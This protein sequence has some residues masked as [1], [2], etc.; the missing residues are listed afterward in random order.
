MNS[1]GDMEKEIA[2]KA[3][4]RLL[5]ELTK[6]SGQ[7]TAHAG[8]IEKETSFLISLIKKTSSEKIDEEEISNAI[9]QA[10]QNRPISMLPHQIPPKGDWLGWLMCGGRGAGKTQALSQYVIDHINGPACLTGPSPHWVAIIAPTLGDAATSMFYGPSG[11]RSMDPTAKLT[12]AAGGLVVKW[13]NESQAK[14]F[15]ARDPED[16]ERLR[17]GGNRCLSILEEL[18]AWRYLEDCFNHMRFGLRVGPR[19]RWIGATTPKPRDLI[20]KIV[21]GEMKNVVVTKAT[22]WDNPYLPEH[23]IESF[24]EEYGKGQLG[25]QELYAEL[26]EQDENALWTRSE[27]DANRVDEAPQLQRIT[28]GVDPSGGRGEQGIIVAGKSISRIMVKDRPKIIEEG[29]V[30]DDRTCRLSPNGW[31]RRA[32]QA[33]IDWEADD[34]VVETNFGGDMAMA[35]ISGAA[36]DMGILIPVRKVIASRGKRPRAEPV[37]ALTSRGHWHHVGRFETLEEQMC[38]WYPELDWSP[39]R[40]DAMVW[41]AWHLKLVRL[42]ARGKG[43]FPGK[44]MGEKVDGR[45]RMDN[46]IDLNS[47]RSVG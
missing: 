8:S 31:G 28:V 16:Q 7:S 46:V 44:E 45:S 25:R 34:I 20:K 42:T 14:L 47:R 1:L 13:P 36:E 5:E 2:G 18:A 30:L 6:A 21:K 17:S 37:S 27:I 4:A 40:M 39:D 29:F 32:V 24:E 23:I 9:I 43:R 35:T 38:I 3:S 41:D 15:G 26:I 19:P 11:I 10:V 33:A 12:N 22:M